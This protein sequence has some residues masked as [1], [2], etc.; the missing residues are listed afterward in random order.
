MSNELRLRAGVRVSTVAQSL[1]LLITAGTN[2]ASGG[3][4]LQTQQ[5]SYLSW[6]EDIDRAL[7]LYFTAAWVWEELYTPRWVEIRGLTPASPRPYP[8]IAGEAQT[9]SDRLK[10]I[11]ERLERSQA[12]F[13]L[14]GKFVAV[15]PDTNVF[16]H[17]RFFD[18]IDW[19]GLVRAKEVRIV[20][21]LLVI[22]QLDEKTYRSDDRGDR[23]KKAI[24]T[25]RKLQAG[26]PTP[27]APADVRAGVSVQLL[28]DPPGH[29]RSG[30][31]DDELLTRAEYL[32]SL[33]DG[34][35]YVATGDYG[36]QAQATL[37]G[38]KCLELPD[39][40]RL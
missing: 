36:M 40:L 23:A 2:L 28:M 30:N 3:R 4:G 22:K 19:P 6:V 10:E 31:D 38:L 18:E 27:E 24:R 17:Y 21:P 12:H 39:D 35:V 14:S 29:Q 20:V 15:V 37:R 13:D 7:H 5:N 9:Q 16:L 32:S 33:T 8:L 34:R 11:V 26:L 25:L 1:K